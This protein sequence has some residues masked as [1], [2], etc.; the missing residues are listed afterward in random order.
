M[1]F[2]TLCYKTIRTKQFHKMRNNLR[3]A[4]ILYMLYSSILIANA[5][6][7]T[8]K[9]EHLELTALEAQVSVKELEVLWS[10]HA[11]CNS[12]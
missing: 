7:D 2:N 5:M 9:I 1:K 8:F 4:I 11:E 3:Y 10:G 6:Q 12:A